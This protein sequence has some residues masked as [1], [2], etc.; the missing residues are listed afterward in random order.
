MSLTDDSERGVLNSAEGEELGDAGSETI[1]TQARIVGMDGNVV[2]T[3][4]EELVN[5]TLPRRALLGKR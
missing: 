5:V 1:L 3:S 2:W 4:G